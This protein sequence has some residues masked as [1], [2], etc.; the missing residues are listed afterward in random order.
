[1]NGDP[2]LSP[3]PVNVASK[4]VATLNFSN[5]GKISLILGPKFAGKSTELIQRMEIYKVFIH[6]TSFHVF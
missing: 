3:G 6:V 2:M 5:G 4:A 1:M